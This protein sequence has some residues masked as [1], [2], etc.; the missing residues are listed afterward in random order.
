MAG[1]N[2]KIPWDLVGHFE[3]RH[4]IPKGDA[5]SL[6]LE[7]K[8]V[9]LS[10]HTVPADGLPPLGARASAD[11]A[12]T[13]FGSHMYTAPNSLR[14]STKRIYTSCIIGSDNGLSPGRRQAII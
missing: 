13:K 11:T 1:V 3:W 9:Y 14:Q 12:M 4:P 10:S 5:G 2:T 8:H 7:I 6:K